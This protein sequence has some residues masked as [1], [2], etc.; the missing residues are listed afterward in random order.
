[1]L[2]GYARR[3]LA[4]LGNGD[5]PIGGYGS[6]NVRVQTPFVEDGDD[7]LFPA[8]LRDDQ[9]SL[10]TFAEHHFVRRHAG[11][12]ARDFVNVDPDPGAGSRRGFDRRARQAGGSQVLKAHDGAGSQSFQAR[13]NQQLFEKG[14][15]DLDHAAGGLLRIFDR[16]ERGALNAVSTSVG[17][18]QDH[19]IRFS[20]RLG[21]GQL[22]VAKQSHA[23]GVDQRIA[24]IA[25]LD[26]HFAADGRDS[27]AVAV[28]TDSPNYSAGQIAVAGGVQRSETERV[29]QRYRA[30][31]HGEY[32]AD[33]PA[34]ARRGS[35]ER[36]DRAG[37]IVAFD[38][39]DHGEAV[40][41]I[42]GS[43]ILLAGL[44]QKRW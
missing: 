26:H 33:Y 36:F 21:P 9:H 31:A 7:F 4:G 8:F 1:M 2:D 12:P 30:R 39:E 6:D 37:V 14:I 43:G 28:G 41:D 29:E 38:L 5:V 22:V 15:T 13:F 18:D 10:L 40:S 34:D 3:G 17:A 20:H 19:R 44:D 32:V 16:S 25:I 24:G 27:D 42:H 23:H 11:G 35:L